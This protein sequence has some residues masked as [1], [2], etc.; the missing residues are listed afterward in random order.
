MQGGFQDTRYIFFAKLSGQETKAMKTKSPHKTHSDTTK[1]IRNLSSS[2]GASDI[3]LRRDG[4]FSS[5]RPE[6]IMTL[7]R[8]GKIDQKSALL[9]LGVAAISAEE[10]AKKHKEISTIDELTQIHNRR[11]FID[12]LSKELAK[13]R[14]QHLELKKLLDKPLSL[15]MMMVDIDFF[16]KVNDT[17]GHLAGDTVLRDVARIIKKE[18]RDNDRVF[19]Y[20]GEEFA[21][22]MTDTGTESALIGAERLRAKVERHSFPVDIHGKKKIKL[23]ISIGIAHVD[24]P[25]LV[26]N[27][28]TDMMI[29]RLIGHADEALYKAKRNGRNMVLAW[30]GDKKLKN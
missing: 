18:M 20:G 1:R 19:R 23:T 12:F 28:V 15:S 11:A 13:L 7:L 17:Y 24:G 14:V 9:L 30:G 22:L 10:E 25:K 27:K 2:L 26:A 8:Q 4:D 6:G 21:V 29:P 16:K 3:F 5:L